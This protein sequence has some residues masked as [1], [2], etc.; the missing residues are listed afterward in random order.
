MHLPPYPSCL[1]LSQAM[2]KH[3]VQVRRLLQYY[4]REIFHNLCGRRTAG[5]WRRW[6]VGGSA[7]GGFQ[8]SS[9]LSSSSSSSRRLFIARR[10]HCGLRQTILNILIS[11]RQSRRHLRAP[12]FRPSGCCDSYNICRLAALPLSGQAV[13]LCVCSV[14]LS[15]VFLCYRKTI[16]L[17]SI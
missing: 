13:G 5:D 10:R 1:P 12:R 15:V 6:T 11:H 14:C 3:I 2:I 7:Q 9:S 4:E 16:N 17:N 8:S